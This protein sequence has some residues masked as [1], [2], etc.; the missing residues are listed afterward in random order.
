VPSELGEDDVMIAIVADDRSS[1]D[2][3]ALVAHC[4]ASLAYF[5]V[6]RYIR[7][8]DAL[9]KTAS[10]RVQKFVLRDEGVTPDAVDR[11]N[12]TRPGRPVSR[13]SP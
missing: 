12:F 11:G 3:D 1:F 8:V 6:P 9:P 4:E 2:V 13:P 10:Q 7:I 5:A